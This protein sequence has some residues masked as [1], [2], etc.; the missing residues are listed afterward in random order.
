MTVVTILFNVPVQ[1]TLT[2]P[3]TLHS[4]LL[5]VTVQHTV[6]VTVAVTVPTILL[7]VT[8]LR[9]KD[10]QNT[11]KAG[12]SHRDMYGLLKKKIYSFDPFETEFLEIC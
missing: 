8:I 3:V 10:L 9:Y 11:C 5:S 1:H 2:V 4:I 7:T 12:M 6:T